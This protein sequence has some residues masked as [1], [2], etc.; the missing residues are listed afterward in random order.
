MKINVDHRLSNEKPS[1]I[2]RLRGT[3]SSDI[4][5]SQALVISQTSGT[6]AQLGIAIEPIEVVMN[7]V[8]GL[9]PPN[10]PVGDPSTLAERVGKHLMNYLSGFAQ[11]G[12]DGHSYV[13]L[14]AVGKWYESFTGKI[15]AGGIGFL[16]RQD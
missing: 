14:S 5:A 11:S 4:S 9:P 3:F 2:F 1:A 13:S 10:K 16:E 15:K 8:S 6:L 7:Q 12:P